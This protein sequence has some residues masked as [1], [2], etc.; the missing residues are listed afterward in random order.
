VISAAKTP[1]KNALNRLEWLYC[2]AQPFLFFTGN[3][4]LA[5]RVN[6]HHVLL[7]G[8]QTRLNL[9]DSILRIFSPRR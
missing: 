2:D 5:L 7:Y 8:R 1:S 4:P 6:H 9:A 3:I